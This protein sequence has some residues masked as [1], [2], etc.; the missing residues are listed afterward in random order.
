MIC[1]ILQQHV[2]AEPGT[3]ARPD[4]SFLPGE[5]MA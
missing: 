5:E 1:A 2:I 4:R 3:D